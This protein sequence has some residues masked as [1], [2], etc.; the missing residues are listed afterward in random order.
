MPPLE[1]DLM[2]TI[3]TLYGVGAAGTVLL[4]ARQIARRGSSCDVS[5]RFFASYAGGYLIWLLY[6]LSIRSLPIIVVHAIGL[7][8]GTLTL[9]TTLAVRGSLFRPRTWKP[10]PE[11]RSA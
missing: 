11:R 7:L 2:A 10:C 9:A 3:A 5:A 8:C 4:Q 6:G 1:P